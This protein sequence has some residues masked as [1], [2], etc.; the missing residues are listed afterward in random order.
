MIKII[1]AKLHGIHVTGAEL[2]YHGSVTL[3]P[4]ICKQVRI[5]PMEF[6]EIWNKNTGSRFST[7]VI[8]GE[9]GS[10][11]C[12]LNGAAARLCQPGDQVIIAAS[13][14]IDPSALADHRPLTATFDADNRIVDLLAYEVSGQHGDDWFEFKTVTELSAPSPSAG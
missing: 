5:Y 12:V 13:E 11:C 9:P 2:H 1:R 14:Y 8:Y 6:V 10:G 3:D 4:E 7:Y